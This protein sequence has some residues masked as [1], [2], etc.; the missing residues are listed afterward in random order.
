MNIEIETIPEKRYD[1][2]VNV[3]V[4]GIIEDRNKAISKR[5]GV[6]P[7][8][9]GV[10]LYYSTT[11]L[12]SKVGTH[13][14]RLGVFSGYV[15]YE[16]SII[17]AHPVAISP[18][19]G[20]NLYKQIGIMGDYTLTKFYMCQ[21][22]YPEPSKYRLYYKYF[23][24][25]LA[26]IISGNFQKTSIEFLIKN[27]SEYKK[28]TKDEEIFMALYVMFEKS[29]VDFIFDNLKTFVEDCDVK[30]SLMKIYKREFKEMVELYK[31]EIIDIEKL[32]KI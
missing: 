11:E 25:V 29:G 31:K 13:D 15:D 9:V 1:A 24:D 5:F 7:R 3:R 32:K 16:D 19:F 27:F 6:E 22:F 20:E 10:K 2:D 28:Y 14:A 18:I 17:I 23:T 21:I 30:K 4:K 8:D 12:V 26:R